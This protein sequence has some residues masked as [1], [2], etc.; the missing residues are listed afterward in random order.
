MLGVFPLF[1][2]LLF[3]AGLF[4]Q[5]EEGT[6]A[7]KAFR[8]GFYEE[9]LPFYADASGADASQKLRFRYGVCAVHLP[10]QRPKGMAVLE[11]LASQGMSEANYWS[12]VGHQLAGRSEKAIQAFH[13]YKSAQGAGDVGMEEVERRIRIAVRQQVLR[14]EKVHVRSRRMRFGPDAE[15]SIAYMDS[16]ARTI[17][18]QEKGKKGQGVGPVR[19]AELVEG[20]LKVTDTVVS[21]AR[22]ELAGYANDGDAVILRAPQKKSPW[23]DD[24]YVSRS[25]DGDWTAPEAFGPTVNTDAHEGSAWMNRNGR[26]MIFSS[27]RE[28]GNGGL[29][30]YIV[31]KLPTGDWAKARNLSPA[32]N[33]PHDEKAPHL[34]P[35]ERTL[36]FLSKGHRT[37]GGT[38]IL[39]SYFEEKEKR[40]IVP[41][42]PGFPVNSPADEEAVSLTREEGRA[43]I[44]RSLAHEPHRVTER[45]EL[46]YQDAHLTVVKGKVLDKESG[47]PVKAKLRVF[48]PRERTVQGIYR[49]R[50]DD[51]SFIFAIRPDKEQELIVEADGYVPKIRKVSTESEGLEIRLKKE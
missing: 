2:L 35:D 22:M 36:Y 50:S 40:W 24:L 8:K 33:T 16:D 31:K 44:T 26:L 51:G 15:A 10:S 42:N 25:K 28:G 21:K 11:E 7:R 38:D 13:A 18:F 43:L 23:K 39:R 49:N 9:A 27:G 3:S 30:L 47:E 1:I 34:M 5:S 29:D 41:E 12:G 20:G 17:V 37:M 14:S 19:I 32:I 48:D 6:S 4:A 46:L 45:F